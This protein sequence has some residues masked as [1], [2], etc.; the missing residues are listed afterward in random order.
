MKTLIPALGLLL[1]TILAARSAAED[2]P[3]IEKVEIDAG[4]AFYVNGKPFFPL[5]AWLQDAKNFSAV[6][7]CGMN[8]TAGYWPQSSGTKDVSEYLTLVDKAGLYGVMPFDPRLTGRS[9]LLA[10]I[11][12][13]EPDLPRKVSDAEVVPAGNLKIN[14]KTPLWKLV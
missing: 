9:N 11:H 1:A 8:T 10:Y 7:Q 14:R 6:K 5:M 2:L 4:R 13:D 12:D 3:P